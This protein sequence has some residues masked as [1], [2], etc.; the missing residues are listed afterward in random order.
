MPRPLVRSAPTP[1]SPQ[2]PQTPRCSA[3]IPQLAPPYPLLPRKAFST[4]RFGR[5]PH[6]E[7]VAGSLQ[8]MKEVRAAG[9]Q[10][11]F[12][13][14]L[15]A[16]DTGDCKKAVTEAHKSVESTMK[17][18]LQKQ[19]GNVGGLLAEV[20]KSGIVPQYYQEFLAH[21]QKLALGAVKE[22]N[23]PGRG[24]GQGAEPQEVSPGLARFALHLAGAINVFLIERWLETKGDQEPEED[25]DIPF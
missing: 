11:E 4:H 8:L 24:H 15:T 9:A 2:R 3:A 23:L 6:E 20:V 17:C 13:A 14:A 10:E 7:I 22:R 16:L 1:R 25:D 21:F 18:V 5:R 12:Q 19:T